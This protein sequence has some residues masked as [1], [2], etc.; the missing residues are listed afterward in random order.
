MK[1]ENKSLVID[2]AVIYE[3]SKELFR[4]FSKRTMKFRYRL[5]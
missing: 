4:K 3:V 1:E 2:D 5:L